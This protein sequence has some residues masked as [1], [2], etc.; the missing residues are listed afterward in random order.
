M[1]NAKELLRHVYLDWNNLVNIQADI[2]NL[3]KQYII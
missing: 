1:T 2:R 3:Y